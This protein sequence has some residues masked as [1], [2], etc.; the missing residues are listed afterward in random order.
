[1][2]VV[3]QF[4]IKLSQW[5]NPYL[6]ELCMAQIGT[7]LVIHSGQLDKYFRKLLKPNPF[8]VRVTG[9]VL[10]NAFGYGVVTIFGARLLARFYLQ[11]GGSVRVPVLFAVFI[12]IGILAERKNQI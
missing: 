6:I 12:L 5:I 8:L 3:S 10:L 9:F 11:I 7:F 1:M 4:F 2:E